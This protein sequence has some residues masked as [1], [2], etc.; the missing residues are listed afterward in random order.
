MEQ[1]DKQAAA[2]KPLCCLRCGAPMKSVHPE[3]FNSG[4]L[5]VKQLAK[6][7]SG[8]GIRLLHCTQ[9][10]KLEFYKKPSE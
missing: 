6:V 10:G 7:M 9:C 1:Q 3:K 4:S 8:A 5:L 2:K